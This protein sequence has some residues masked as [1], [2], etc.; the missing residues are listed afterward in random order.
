M[1]EGK[2]KKGRQKPREAYT[3]EQL[4]GRPPKD[5]EYLASELIKW[6]KAD[7][8]NINLCGFCSDY[9]LSSSTFF[10]WVD[11][12]PMFSEAYHKAKDHLGSKRERLLNEGKLHPMTFT[13][14]IL[15]YDSF[16]KR[17]KRQENVFEASLAK[18]NL[19]PDLQAVQ[20]QN[21]A[22]LDQIR[23][24]QNQNKKV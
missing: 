9:D 15:T 20:E 6:V 24:Y 14:N 13:K 1:E 2:K 5:R 16:N 8:K 18:E 17:S 10:E 4:G 7:E 3:P 22:I 21:K 11:I 12:D 23:E 19:T